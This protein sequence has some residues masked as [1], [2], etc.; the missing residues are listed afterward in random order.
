MFDVP[1]PQQLRHKARP[2][3]RE[4]REGKTHRA[5]ASR[6]DDRSAIPSKLIV[7]SFLFDALLEEVS[8]TTTTN[9][10]S[11][12]CSIVFFPL[13][14][15]C[16]CKIFDYSY[17]FSTPKILPYMPPRKHRH[18]T[19]QRPDRPRLRPW[20]VESVMTV[21]WNTPIVSYVKGGKSSTSVVGYSLYRLFSSMPS[22]LNGRRHPSLGIR[23]ENGCCSVAYH[24]SENG[25]R[26]N[27]H[28]FR[29]RWRLLCEW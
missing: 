14:H 26:C 16:N 5:N 7:S 28:E 25:T 19:F 29:E 6:S 23:A 17:V 15:H 10:A 18:C 3:P 24:A 11:Q 2:I 1:P 12:S 8:E 20:L 22:E 9:G 13:Y 27:V 4:R 21:A